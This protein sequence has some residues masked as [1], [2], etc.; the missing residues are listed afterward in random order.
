MPRSII[1]ATPLVNGVS[2][3][4]FNLKN[5]EDSP[6]SQTD[7]TGE[8]GLV[9]AF[10]HGTWCPY[11]MYQLK[12]LNRIM[13]R[14]Q[15]LGVTAA[16]ISKDEPGVLYGY[17]QSAQPPLGYP[18][19][20]DATPSLS[21]TFGVYDAEHDSPFAAVFY[22]DADGVIRYSDVSADPDCYPNLARLLEV[23]E[24]GPTGNPFAPARP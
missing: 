14:L 17:E 18:L 11:C 19:L 24:F 3:P 16:C 15:E 23:I 12:R 21:Q 10:Q 7:L 5:S 2:M 22:A 13:P 4:S 6:V 1:T 20:A 9:L 8:N